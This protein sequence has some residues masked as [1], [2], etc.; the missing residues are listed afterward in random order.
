[1]LEKR[2]RDFDRMQ[3]AGDTT[4]ILTDSGPEKAPEDPSE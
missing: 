3:D 1:M 2:E 4:S